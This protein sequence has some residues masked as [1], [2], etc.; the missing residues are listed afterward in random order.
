MIG[1]AV[2]SFFV[3]FAWLDPIYV[4]A[5][6]ITG[7]YVATREYTEDAGGLGVPRTTPAPSPGITRG[8]RVR[9]SAQRFLTTAPT[10]LAGIKQCTLA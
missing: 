6:F 10:S 9:Q 8:W 5:A 1:F 4:M 7:L 3:S 2:T